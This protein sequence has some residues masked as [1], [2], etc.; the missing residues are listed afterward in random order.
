MTELSGGARSIRWMSCAR[1]W[2]E[3][4]LVWRLD[5]FHVVGRGGVG[6]GRGLG[7]LL[8]GTKMAGAIVTA[9]FDVVVL[10]QGWNHGGAAG[11]LADAIEHDLS[12]AVVEFDGAVNLDGAA[13][14]AAHVADIFQAGREDHDREGAGHLLFAEV[15]EV[16]SFRADFNAQHLSGYAFGLADMLTGFVY[17]DAI[18]G[19]ESWCGEQEDQHCDRSP[20][21]GHGGGTRCRAVSRRTDEGVRP[22]R[23]WGDDCILLRHTVILGEAQ[24]R[25]Q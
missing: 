17:G 14:E 19:V 5:A 8:G 20:Y 23:S 7:R 15:E 25:R 12:A 3:S 13:R 21:P 18:G 11:D 6:R 4:R 10:R 1:E 16:N 2:C 9:V 24:Q 22:S